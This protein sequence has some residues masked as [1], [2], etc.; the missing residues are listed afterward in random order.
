MGI[1]RSAGLAVGLMLV[2]AGSAAAHYN[3]IFPE[4]FRVS[5]GEMM[6]IGYHAADSFPESTQ[7]PKRLQS[8]FLHTAKTSVP[9]GSFR[10]DGLRQVATIMP[11][12]GY[13][14]LSAVN[15]AK[16]DEMKP[17]SFLKYLQ[18]ERL[19]DAIESREKMGETGKPG[20]ERYSMYLKSIV[21]AGAPNDGYRHIVGLPIEIVPEKDP[22]QVK[23]GET[24]PVRVLY[25]GVPAANLQ[26]FA[27]S[28]GKATHHVGKTDA[29]GRIAVPVGPG[30]WR[31]H[32]IM[33]KRISE[34]EADWES[35]WATLTFDIP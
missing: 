9:I 25:R 14:V 5:P 32:T 6:T 16:T 2:L 11:P 24:L 23:S 20:K 18:D 21:L 19:S 31:L 10:E 27:A 22:S 34:P 15:P 3:F 28:K 13:S 4:K 33:M 7:L 1:T 26:L 30:P 17:E 35:F 12:S 29:N 8:A